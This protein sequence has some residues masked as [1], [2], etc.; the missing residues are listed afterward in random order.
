M[1]GSNEIEKRV[2]AE[3]MKSQMR[4]EAEFPLPLSNEAMAVVEQAGQECDPG[5]ITA[6]NTSLRQGGTTL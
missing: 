4:K 3:N 2:A 1:Q 6:L 5:I